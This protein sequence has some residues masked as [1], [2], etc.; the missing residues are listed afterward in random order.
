MVGDFFQPKRASVVVGGQFGSEAKGLAA[1][2]L[3]MHVNRQNMDTNLFI[4][5]TNAGAQAGHTTVLED[6]TRFICYHLPTL[7]VLLSESTIYL[8]AGSIIDVDLLRHEIMTVSLALGRDVKQIANRIVIHPNAAHITEGARVAE[9]GI[10]GITAHLG[11]TQKGV[12]AALADK[13]MRR[14]QATMGS[15]F[16][17]FWPVHGIDDIPIRAID[18]NDNM[19]R[20]GTVSVEIPQGT[21]LS[22]SNGEFYPKCTS[23]DCWIGS[24]LADAG[25]HPKW[26]DKSLMVCRTFPIRVGNVYAPHT[27]VLVGYSGAFYPDSKELDWGADMPSVEPER[28]TVTKRVRRIAS[29]SDDQYKSAL[30]LNNPTHVMITFI[31]YLPA[32]AAFSQFQQR[33]RKVHFACGIDPIMLYSWGPKVHEVGTYAD[34]SEWLMNREYP[35]LPAERA[36]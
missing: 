5:T 24:G 22:L 10:N 36:E 12:G 16:G 4:C 20:G 6:G 35:N 11:S 9:A 26:L 18:L 30:M 25:I 19:K 15:M 27:G 2:H 17:D 7:G 33:L 1:A 3:A 23:R 29:W 32:P 28:T 21:G 14:P 13:I 31:N 8:N 34:A